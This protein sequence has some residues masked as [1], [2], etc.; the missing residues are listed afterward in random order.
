MKNQMSK[1]MQNEL[2]TGITHTFSWSL[3]LDPTGWWKFLTARILK[4]VDLFV[5][6]DI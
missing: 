6:W 2:A 3:G 1:N 4:A 5:V